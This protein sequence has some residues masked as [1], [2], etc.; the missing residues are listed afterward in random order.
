MHE[1]DGLE[2]RMAPYSPAYNSE[3]LEGNEPKESVEKL[4]HEHQ[5]QEVSNIVDQSMVQQLQGA[6]AVEG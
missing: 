2:I 3:L 6:D 1:V 4:M 5:E